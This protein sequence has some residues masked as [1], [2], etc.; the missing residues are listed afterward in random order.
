MANWGLPYQG[1]KGAHVH[2]IFRAITQRSSGGSHLYDPFCGGFAVSHYFLSH[3]WSVTASDADCYQI[4]LLKA[5]LEGD[6][7]PSLMN[8][9]VPRQLFERCRDDPAST[10]LSDAEVQFVR[11]VWSFGNTGTCYLYGRPL[12]ETKRLTH[13]LVVNGETALRLTELTGVPVQVQE[14]VAKLPAG[15]RHAGWKRAYALAG[16]RDPSKQQSK[17]RERAARVAALRDT[18]AELA[19]Q[20]GSGRFALQNLEATSRIAEFSLAGRAGLQCCSYETTLAHLPAG[21]DIYLDPPY[22]GTEVYAGSET[23]DHPRFWAHATDL[24]RQGHRVYVS[25]YTAPPDWKPILAFSRP[26]RMSADPLAKT[27]Y[28]R[29][30]LFVHRTIE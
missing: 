29:E 10:G 18:T 17:H 16:G 4:A 8:E 28:H 22:E 30:K 15:S 23:F 26:N 20:E 14:R 2:R 5:L 21:S 3:G 11:L 24:A 12:E 6:G 9:W 19:S 1:S 27:R 25:E 7:V 13:R